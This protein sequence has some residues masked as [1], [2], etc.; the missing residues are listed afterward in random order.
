MGDDQFIKGLE[1]QTWG[2][3]RTP[4]AP[5]VLKTTTA[6]KIR[7]AERERDREQK[8]LE[9]VRLEVQRKEHQKEKRR[10]SSIEQAAKKKVAATHDS[11]ASSG[12]RMIRRV[13]ERGVGLDVGPGPETEP[14]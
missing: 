8:T 10:R 4:K 6:Q 12:K 7:A 11:E 14:G 3:K 5:T 1:T 2:E 9:K 13:R